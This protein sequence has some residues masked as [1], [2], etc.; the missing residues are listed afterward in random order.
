MPRRDPRLGLVVAAGF[1]Q[2]IGEMERWPSSPAR[3]L[4]WWWW[5]RSAAAAGAVVLRDWRT[6]AGGGAQACGEGAARGHGSLGELGKKREGG[7]GSVFIALGGEIVAWM[8]GNGWRGGVVTWAR[9]GGKLEPILAWE[10]GEESGGSRA[11]SGPHG[12]G[13]EGV[14]GGGDV[15]R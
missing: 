14:G 3:R 6:P 7:A 10:V 4:S 11:A 1:R 15:G 5:R 12:R 9:G 2:G 13:R 8:G